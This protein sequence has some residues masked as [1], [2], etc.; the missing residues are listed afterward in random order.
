M[1]VSRLFYPAGIRIDTTYLGH[2]GEQSVDNGLEDVTIFPSGDALPNF[3]GGKMH[4]PE[5]QIDTQDLAVALAL[6]TDTGIAADLIAANVDL[7]FREAKPQ[8]LNEDVA[9]TAKHQVY[10]LQDN[11][12]LYWDSLQWSQDDDAAKLAIKCVPIYNGANGIIQVP[13]EAIEAASAQVA[14]WTGGPLYINGTLISG[15][16]S[17]QWANNVEVEKV[18]AD[19][20]AFPTLVTIKKVRPVITIETVDLRAIAA[21]DADGTA[22]TN[23]THYLRRRKPSKLIYPDNDAQHIKLLATAGSLKWK[24]SGGNPATATVEI[25]LHKGAGSLFTISSGQTVVAGTTTT[26]TT[27]TTS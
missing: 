27:T 12:L 3:T 26:T 11:A 7:F 22:V 2:V 20:E 13:A 4:A 19:G 14:P 21:L 24:K 18:A 9:E 5:Y 23:F 8:G 16:K 6:F 10:R 15:V 1:S 25:H 17:L